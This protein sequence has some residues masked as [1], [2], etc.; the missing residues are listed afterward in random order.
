V[1]GDGLMRHRQGRQSRII[2][3][4]ARALVLGFT[5]VS[6]FGLI[7]R[8][9]AVRGQESRGDQESQFETRRLHLVATSMEAEGINHPAVLRAMRT[10][11][12]HRFVP[13]RLRPLA[14][15]D[16]A[17]PIGAGQTISQPSLVAM[18]TAAI[19]PK[20]KMRVL[21]IGTGSGYQAAV[22]SRCV[23][24]VETIEVIPSLGR[25]AE[26]TL[27]ALG[28]ANV[29]VH[30][31]DG[32]DGWPERAPYDAVI[33]TAAPKRV[34]KPLLDQLKVGG[35]LVAPVG[36]VDQNLIVIT[37]TPQGLVTES[38]AA[39]RFVPMTGKVQSDR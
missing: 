33:L 36:Q 22:L 4:S 12:R 15:E 6:G 11:P 18:M 14:Y 20:P 29:H 3:L 24:E 2:L 32:Y 7:G 17:L 31:G 26:S 16:T 10:V 9:Q 39:V 5:L 1:K 37:K 13:D 25:Q 38:I 8:E 21:E 19:R 34:P 28:Y 27:R 30:I 35:R 23:A